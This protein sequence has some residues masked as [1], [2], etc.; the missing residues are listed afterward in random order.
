MTIETTDFFLSSLLIYIY[1]IA[2]RDS[3]GS[4]VRCLQSIVNLSLSSSLTEQKLLLQP[5]RLSNEKHASTLKI[6]LLLCNR[7]ARMQP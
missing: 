5:I 7:I 1:S 6:N 3:V 4:Y 2:V